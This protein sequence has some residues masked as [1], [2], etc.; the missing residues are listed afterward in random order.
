VKTSC[1]S[2]ENINE[3]PVWNLKKNYIVFFFQGGGQAW[4]ANTDI[5]PAVTC[6]IIFSWSIKQEPY[7]KKDIRASNNGQSTDNV[8]SNP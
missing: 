3:I 8:W 7:K 5:F 1:P 6:P 4:P 2:T